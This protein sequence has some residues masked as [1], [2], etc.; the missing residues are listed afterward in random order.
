MK[1]SQS[2]SMG[3]QRGRSGS[4]WW[5]LL[6]E[7]PDRSTNNAKSRPGPGTFNSGSIL[8]EF[9]LCCQMYKLSRNWMVGRT[10]LPLSGIHPGT[11]FVFI[12]LSTFRSLGGE[13]V[14]SV[15]KQLGEIHT[16]RSCVCLGLEKGGGTRARATV[17]VQWWEQFLQE[18]I[19]LPGSLASSGEG[20]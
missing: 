6:V 5:H 18:A 11:M 7:E 4:W 16:T 15:I 14:H 8:E 12:H 20:H 13:V 3:L 1:S 2:P 10:C 19:Q 17:K 9:P